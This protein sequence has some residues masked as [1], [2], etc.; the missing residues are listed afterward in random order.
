[1]VLIIHIQQRALRHYNQ[2]IR[3]LV[4]KTGVGLTGLG[5][6][7]VTVCV[8]HHRNRWSGSEKRKQ[9][10]ELK[11]TGRDAASFASL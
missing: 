1:V 7:P 2:V 11:K 6:V 4:C 10:K 9:G 3:W 8:S 5:A